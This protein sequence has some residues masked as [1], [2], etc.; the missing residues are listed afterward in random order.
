[1]EINHFLAS[2]DFLFVRSLFLNLNLGQHI[3]EPAGE[4]IKSFHKEMS[5]G[6]LLKLQQ[7]FSVFLDLLM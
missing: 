3:G 7:V 1:M 5:T 6:V 2:R 4:L